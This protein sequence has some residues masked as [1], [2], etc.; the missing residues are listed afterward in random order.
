MRHQRCNRW[1]QELCYSRALALVAQKKSSRIVESLFKP[2][3]KLASSNTGP[4]LP[5][6]TA[7]PSPPSSTSTLPSRPSAALS[8]S[9]VAGLSQ[10]AVQVVDVDR[11]PDTSCSDHHQ[12]PLT[13]ILQRQESLESAIAGLQES[14]PV[15]NIPDVLSV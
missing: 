8:Y 4:S 5:S 11:L 10:S 2:K 13:A 15:G 1:R 3:P 14:I 12:L 7:V 6:S 9:A